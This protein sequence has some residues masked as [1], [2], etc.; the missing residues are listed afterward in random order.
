MARNRILEIE[1]PTLGISIEAHQ[2]S[3]NRKY[4]DAFCQ[5][6]PF[7]SIQ[8]HTLVSGEVIHSYCPANSLEYMELVEKRVLGNELPQGIVSWGALGSVSIIYRRLKEPEWQ[9]PIA[10]V[11]EQYHTGLEKVG[12]AA[13]EAI[14]NTKELIEVHFRLKGEQE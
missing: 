4:F 1:W 10:I 8:Q 7:T 12:R 14:F 5:Y 6:L 11:H 2:L 3:Y 9:I 13:W